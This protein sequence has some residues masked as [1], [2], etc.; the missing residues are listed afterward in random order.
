MFPRKSRSYSLN[1]VLHVITNP[2]A[3][4]FSYCNDDTHDN[5]PIYHHVVEGA[6]TL[7]LL[8]IQHF[9]EPFHPRQMDRLFDHI[10]TLLLSS[11][12]RQTSFEASLLPS[13]LL[14]FNTNIQWDD[15]QFPELSLIETLH[16]LQILLPQ[17]SKH[18]FN[19]H[20]HK[21]NNNLNGI[22]EMNC[23]EDDFTLKLLIF[24]GHILT[25]LSC[26]LSNTTQCDQ[27]DSMTN[28][29]CHQNENIVSNQLPRYHHHE[30]QQQSL[31][32]G[33]LSGFNENA[34]SSLHLL[35][36]INSITSP[37]VR[38][39]STNNDKTDTSSWI[40]RMVKSHILMLNDQMENCENDIDND[41][42]QNIIDLLQ[43]FV[44]E[45][46]LFS[47]RMNKE[48]VVDCRLFNKSV[49]LAS[50]FLRLTGLFGVHL[51]IYTDSVKLLIKWV[52][53]LV[54]M[55]DKKES[56]EMSTSTHLAKCREL[57]FCMYSE[58]VSQI[59]Q[60]RKHC[61][62]ES[63][64]AMQSGDLNDMWKHVTFYTLFLF[65]EDDGPRTSICLET[66]Q[67]S[68]LQNIQR[69]DNLAIDMSSSNLKKQIKGNDKDSF[70]SVLMLQV[71]SI[72]KLCNQSLKRKWSTYLTKPQSKDVSESQQ[73]SISELTKIQ[74]ICLLHQ[75][76]KF[77]NMN[78][79][80]SGN[81]EQD[82]NIS[83]TSALNEQREWSLS[84]LLQP[85][86]KHDS[87][88]PKNVSKSH[89]ERS[90]HQNALE[91]LK[92]CTPSQGGNKNLHDN[93]EIGDF[94]SCVEEKLMSPKEK[95]SHGQ[96]TDEVISHHEKNCVAEISSPWHA[97]IARKIM[98]TNERLDESTGNNLSGQS[99]YDCLGVSAKSK[100]A[101]AVCQEVDNIVDGTT[102]KT[103]D[104]LQFSVTNYINM[105][106][107]HFQTLE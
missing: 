92:N 18:H 107:I 86:I 99:D 90:Q 20:N 60:S 38:Q 94:A 6:T 63:W 78:V 49:N 19:I 82:V 65:L 44:A 77:G 54:I 13:L 100:D 32:L 79:D 10:V 22:L 42:L 85:L 11:S 58:I 96:I 3:D 23:M 69:V 47:T 45:M 15:V 46:I 36:Q 30:C 68:T 14:L 37:P 39:F 33:D 40:F 71:T 17:I 93:D 34:S 91:N 53:S 52:K 95:G 57:L 51:H 48:A 104:T 56:D 80:S 62:N 16:L 103:S 5:C 50:F 102:S 7:L 83:T 76:H 8:W 9:H 75:I 21:I 43:S 67:S 59:E 26:I 81:N 28:D 87:S 29:Q 41:Y 89:V 72:H 105:I 106:P 97:Y 64:W 66:N 61:N 98:E 27:N 1:R 73:E 101:M 2:M 24:V 35:S 4:F 88:L 25:H 12:C 84:Q 70:L 55:M 31:P 74:F